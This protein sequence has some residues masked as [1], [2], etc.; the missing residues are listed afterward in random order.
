[1]FN[2][3]VKKAKKSVISDE[4]ISELAQPHS[5]YVISCYEDEYYCKSHNEGRCYRGF[6]SLYLQAVYGISFA[7][8]QNIP[9]F[10]DF[11]NLDYSYTDEGIFGNL[12]FWDNYFIQDTLKDNSIHILNQRFENF[13]LKIWDRRFF[14]ELNQ[15]VAGKII[16][17]KTLREELEEVKKEI[18][19]QK[20]LGIHIRKTDHSDE[21]KGVEDAVFFRMVKKQMRNFDRIFIA[22]D[23]QG[24]INDYQSK[25]PG[26]V[27]THNF[28]RSLD[29]KAIHQQPE[30]FG[31]ELG[32]QAIIDCYSL[33]YCSKLIL[34]P[35]NLSYVSLLLNPEI[36]YTLI[37]SWEAKVQRWR[38]LSAYYLNKL[39]IRKW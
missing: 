22:T 10:V 36:P 15:Q 1:M 31:Y 27:I 32:R 39:G 12:N 18:Q 24:V 4:R 20:T 25:F 17:Q 21:V 19:S 11:G 3:R 7:Q 5:V 2:Y 13:P 9:A 14:R 34:S 38:T 23:E 35:S 6:F 16:L 30:N 29:G 33:S 8:K 37:E 26:K 28:L